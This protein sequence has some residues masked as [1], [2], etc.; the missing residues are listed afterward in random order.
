MAK[1]IQLAEAA[2][3]LGVSPEKLT[4]LRSQNKI[5]GYRDGSTWKFKESELERY[6]AQEVIVPPEAG[7]TAADIQMMRDRGGKPDPFAVMKDRVEEKDV[8]QMLATRIGV[9]DDEEIVIGQGVQ[10][11]GFGAGLKDRADGLCR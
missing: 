10:I 5:F 3:L 11:I 6:A 8:L 9:V 1:L 2:E 7:R 4:E